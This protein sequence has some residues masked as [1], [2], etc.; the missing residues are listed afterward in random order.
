M[1]ACHQD[2]DSI[3]SVQESIMHLMAICSLK[4]H[5]ALQSDDPDAAT[6]FYARRSELARELSTSTERK[7]DSYPPLSR[8]YGFLVNDYNLRHKGRRQSM[9]EMDTLARY[10]R[11]LALAS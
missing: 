8:D 9:F 2:I 6:A 3:E 5:E 4:I 11:Q 10:G 1:N 7:E